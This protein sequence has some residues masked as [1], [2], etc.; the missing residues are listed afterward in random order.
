MQSQN[1]GH[2]RADRQAIQGG[3]Q[4]PARGVFRVL[5]LVGPGWDAQSTNRAAPHVDDMAAKRNVADKSPS[6]DARIT[7]RGREITHHRTVA[8]PVRQLRIV[9]SARRPL[10][11]QRSRQALDTG[12]SDDD[13]QR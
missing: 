10:S 3:A 9:Q 2:D 8:R 4:A 6:L 1:R 7:L 12:W 5:T 11:V 13:N